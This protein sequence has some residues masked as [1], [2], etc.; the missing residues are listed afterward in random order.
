MIPMHY[1]TDEEVLK[2][3]LESIGLIEPPDARVLWIK[4]TLDLGEVEVSTA[5]S[6]EMKGRGD[7]EI[8]SDPRPLRLDEERNLV[9]FEAFGAGI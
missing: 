7:L 4:N 3:A 2:I 5:Y 6:E 9:S 1:P 8:L